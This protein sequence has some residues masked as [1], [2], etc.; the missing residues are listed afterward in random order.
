MA[1]EIVTSLSLAARHHARASS[2]GAVT[3]AMIAAIASSE[4][5]RRVIA[6]Q[7]RKAVLVAVVP[8]R[9]ARPG[10]EISGRVGPFPTTIGNPGTPLGT[11]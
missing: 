3:L 7:E 8:W 5:S 9:H 11:E 2:L 4:L 6:V 1:Q 10:N